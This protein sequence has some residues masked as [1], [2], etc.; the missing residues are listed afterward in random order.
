MGGLGRV[1]WW[2]WIP[3]R[4]WRIVAMVD[5]AD[6]IPVRLPAK[7][8]VIVGSLQR[9]KWLAFDCPCGTGHRIMVTLDPSHAPHWTIVDKRPLSVSPSV[10]YRGSASRCHYFI[11]HGKTVWANDEGGRRGRK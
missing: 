8:V 11:R 7:G 4:A 5:A 10:D 2:Q 1:P 6:E 9:P 3:F